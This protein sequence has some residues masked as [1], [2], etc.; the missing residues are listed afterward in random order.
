MALSPEWLQ[1]LL[2]AVP[3]V[4]GAVW[5]LLGLGALQRRVVWMSI[6]E[7]APALAHS[8]GGELRPRWL[9][10]RLQAAQVCVDWTCGL[11]GERTR[12]RSGNRSETRAGLI[13]ERALRGM[14][15]DLTRAAT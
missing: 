9:G 4:L 3:V 12:V 14:I 1:V 6:S 15:E 5:L 8:L 2:T 7:G 11:R 10:Y 13:Q